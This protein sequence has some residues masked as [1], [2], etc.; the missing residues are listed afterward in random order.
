MGRK[1]IDWFKEGLD[2]FK[3]PYPKE[4]PMTLE[5]WLRGAFEVTVFALA[6][7][8]LWILVN[9]IVYD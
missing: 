4:P 6:I 1:I 9:V 2:E 7:V 8:A 3:S 5:E